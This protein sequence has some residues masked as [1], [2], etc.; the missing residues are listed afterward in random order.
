M[1]PHAH[2][3]RAAL[4]DLADML[5]AQLHELHKDPSPDRCERMTVQLAHVQT[6]VRRLCA[7]QLSG[8]SP[9]V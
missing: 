3:L 1:S 2:E 5:A 7:E 4:P 9:T 8:E 6:H